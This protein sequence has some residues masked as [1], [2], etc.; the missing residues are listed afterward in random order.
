M[1]LLGAVDD[2]RPV[3]DTAHVCLGMGGSALRSLAFAKPLVVQGEGGFFCTLDPESVDQFL[4]RGW[5]G[6]DRLGPEQAVDRLVSELVPLLADP[7]RRA[8]LGTFGRGLVAD[9][10]SLEAGVRVLETVY[11]DALASPG[12]ARARP[13]RSLGA[14]GAWSLTRPR[15]GGDVAGDQWPWTTSTP[16]RSSASSTA[17][18]PDLQQLEQ[19]VG[20]TLPGVLLGEVARRATFCASEGSRGQPCDCSGELPGVEAVCTS[21]DP[22]TVTAGSGVDT[23]GLRR[24]GSRG[25]S[26]GSW[27]G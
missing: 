2:P 12:A 24:R 27:R 26:T 15:V 22:S 13:S 1:T 5:Y 16:D 20:A 4:L 10:F 11:E 14:A 3:Y 8:T 7:A 25:S 9:R 21:G 6:L 23:T 18:S 19:R 17:G